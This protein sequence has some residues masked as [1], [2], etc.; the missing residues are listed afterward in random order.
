MKRFL[1]LA[2][3]ALCVVSSAAFA[4][5]RG[6]YIS[7]PEAYSALSVTKGLPSGHVIT[8]DIPVHASLLG[9]AAVPVAGGGVLAD[10]IAYARPIAS[11]TQP[12]G[13]ATSPFTRQ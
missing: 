6:D 5:T 1:I 8:F 12:L 9:Q 11:V 10:T 13:M 4:D 2:S 7:H 3:L